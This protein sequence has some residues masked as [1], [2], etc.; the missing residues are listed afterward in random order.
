MARPVV[1]IGMMGAG[2]STVGRRL[3]KR[4]ALPFRDA[5][6]EIETAAGMTIAD[7]FDQF[8]EAYFRE[9]EQR[10]IG[11][12]LSG[13]PCVLATGGGAFINDTTRA[14]ILERST[15]VWLHASIDVLVARVSRRSTRPLL[16][17]RDPREVLTSLA[18]KRDPIYAQ[19]H[20][21]IDTNDEPQEHVVSRIVK[22]LAACP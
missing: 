16:I 4:L 7:I 15:V 14:L 1:L 10:V 22:A 17:G 2:K 5:D 21:R 3:A 18:E 19:A 13:G 8:G 11:R 6:T 9:G 12:L 20:I